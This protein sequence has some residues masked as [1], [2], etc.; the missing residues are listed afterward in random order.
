M[1]I[2]LLA[3]LGIFG[4]IVGIAMD[5]PFVILISFFVFIFLIGD[6]YKEYG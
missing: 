4:I 2:I 1:K 5:E 3:I 6:V